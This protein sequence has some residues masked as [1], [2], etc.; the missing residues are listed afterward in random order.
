M[1]M[2]KEKVPGRLLTEEQKV[3]QR[4]LREARKRVVMMH[5]L[6]QNS[7]LGRMGGRDMLRQAVLNLKG[8]IDRPPRRGIEELAQQPSSGEGEV[9]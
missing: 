4:G 1:K 5:S 7:A 8:M 9:Q 2:V 3:Y 6:M